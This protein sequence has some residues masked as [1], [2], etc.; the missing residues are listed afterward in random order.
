MEY[1][2]ARESAGAAIKAPRELYERDVRVRALVQSCAA[3]AQQEFGRVDPEKADRDA[4]EIAT[5]ACMLL[6]GRIYTEDAEIVALRYERDQYRKL[7][8]DTLLGLPRIPLI[9]DPP[10]P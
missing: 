10:R 1:E 5:R 6:A 4:N 2:Q 7:A 3:F 9:P 8:E